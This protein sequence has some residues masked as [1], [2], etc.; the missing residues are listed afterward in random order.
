MLRLI[1]PPPRAH[2]SFS[3]AHTEQTKRYLTKSGFQT[4]LSWA[5]VWILL[6]FALLMR[7]LA[8]IRLLALGKSLTSSCKR[9]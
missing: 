5:N 2:L 1:P 4:D 6:G 9:D 8:F 7:A 3:L